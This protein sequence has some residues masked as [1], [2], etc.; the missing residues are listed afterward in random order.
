MP[1]YDIKVVVTYDYE[2]EA[3]NEQE[4]EQMGWEY[5]DYAYSAGVYS[6]DVEEQQ[7]EGVE[8]DEE[9]I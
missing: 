1:K 3:E 9:V 5:E 4:A 7:E 8:L 6:I 2:V